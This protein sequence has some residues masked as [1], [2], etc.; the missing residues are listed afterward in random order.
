MPFYME[1]SFWPPI[2]TPE[3]T[4]RLQEW[5][6]HLFVHRAAPSASLPNSLWLL[7][8]LTYFDVMCAHL[9]S[10]LTACMTKLE[11]Q[12]ARAVAIANS[13]DEDTTTIRLMDGWGRFTMLLMYHIILKHG[14]T[15]LDQL[16]FEIVDIDPAT[17]RY[18]ESFFSQA[19]NISCIQK[20][21]TSMDYSPTI[22]LYMNF[23][24]F[25]KSFHSTQRYLSSNLT[26]YKYDDVD[27]NIF[28]SFSTARTA[29]QLDY[30]GNLNAFLED[31]D[32]QFEEVAIRRDFETWKLTRRVD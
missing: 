22:L 16:K 29:A 12:D 27:P 20:D 5:Q 25:S 1:P 21:I 14:V 17:Q 7:H 8:R 15:I 19:A 32:F 4:A 9:D 13:V 2:C 26:E 24:G 31:T 11:D 28:I 18:H 30:S 23:C 3:V 6:F 10:K